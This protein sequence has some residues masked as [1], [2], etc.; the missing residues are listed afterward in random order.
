MRRQLAHTPP[1]GPRAQRCPRSGP[2]CPASVLALVLTAL[3]LARPKD[4]AQVKVAEAVLS[5]CAD[6]SGRSPQ[7]AREQNAEQPQFF[8]SSGLAA[9]SGD[10]SEDCAG[11][12]GEGD[13]AAPGSVG[14]R[15]N[16][17]GICQL[18]EA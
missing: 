10:L 8:P 7:P 15:P 1:R 17:Q 16:A 18:A 9:G 14:E 3:Q 11:H 2:G 4:P 5:W 6:G 13:H 12:W